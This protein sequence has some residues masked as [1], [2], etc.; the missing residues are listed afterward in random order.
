MAWRMTFQDGYEPYLTAEAE[1]EAICFEHCGDGGLD[2]TACF[3]DGCPLAQVEIARCR[4]FIAERERQA[5]ARRPDMIGG[6]PAHLLLAQP[7]M[8]M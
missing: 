1:A 8:Y 6:V 4:G 7:W 2:K 5:A 3:N